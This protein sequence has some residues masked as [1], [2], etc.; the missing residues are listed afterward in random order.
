MSDTI[1]EQYLIGSF[2]YCTTQKY[3]SGNLVDESEKYI[4]IESSN[5]IQQ[6]ILKE[7][8]NFHFVIG[9]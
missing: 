7:E 3:L 1:V 5:G 9:E 6:E 2:V 8:F 4:V